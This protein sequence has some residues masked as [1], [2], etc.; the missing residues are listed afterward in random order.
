MGCDVISSYT[1][2]NLLLVQ[3]NN[4]LKIFNVYLFLRMSDKVREGRARERGRQ[5]L[6]Q[7][8][9]SELSAKSWTWGLELLNREITT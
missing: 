6:K 2:P 4:N 1:L 7:A 5:N 8:L 3:R 9:G